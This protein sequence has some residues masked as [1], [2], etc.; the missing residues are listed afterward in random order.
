MAEIWQKN[1]ANLWQK[2]GGNIV[3]IWPKYGE[4]T[5]E[6]Q[7]KYGGNMQQNYSKNDKN[8]ILYKIISMS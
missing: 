1:T 4:N 7:W 8:R 5:V 3:T 6:I 2:Y